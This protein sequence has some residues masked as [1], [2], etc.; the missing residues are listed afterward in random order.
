MAIWFIATTMSWCDI[1]RNCWLVGRYCTIR[2][3][4]RILFY[5]LL[6]YSNAMDGWVGFVRTKSRQATLPKALHNVCLRALSRLSRI[7]F[8]TLVKKN[9]PANFIEG[10][11]LTKFSLIG[12]ALDRNVS[13]VV[14]KLKTS[15]S[16]RWSVYAMTATRPSAC[17]WL[18]I[19]FYSLYVIKLIPSRI[20]SRL[21]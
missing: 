5:H 10:K 15:P 20:Q 18:P 13:Y 17:A 3:S 16:V 21:W 12:T 1:W 8:I 19:L 9:H 6:L 2:N 11:D 7:L 14:G 4:L